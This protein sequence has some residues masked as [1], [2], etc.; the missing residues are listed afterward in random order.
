[1]LSGQ[2]SNDVVNPIA[3]FRPLAEQWKKVVFFILQAIQPST[4]QAYQYDHL[5]GFQTGNTLFQMGVSS[6]LSHDCV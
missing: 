3:W 2:L 4:A 5:A 6:S 1:V